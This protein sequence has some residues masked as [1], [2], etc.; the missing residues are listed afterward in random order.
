M[1]RNPNPKPKPSPTELTERQQAILD[2]LI[3][4][5]H[6]NGYQPSLREIGEYFGISSPSGVRCH[7]LALQVKGRI[8]LPDPPA[9][10]AI[11]ILRED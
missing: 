11:R 8:C 9:A 7:L 6:E 2:Y 1:P 4:F 10:R 5:V 3:E